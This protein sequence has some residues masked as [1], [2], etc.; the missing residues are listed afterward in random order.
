MQSITHVAQKNV[1]STAVTVK[2]CHSTVNNIHF[3]SEATGSGI[4]RR[5]R[6]ACC[7]LAC[8]PAGWSLRRQQGGLQDQDVK[9]VDAVKPLSLS[10][11]S[12]FVVLR[13]SPHRWRCYVSFWWCRALLCWQLL[14]HRCFWDQPSGP[15]SQLTYV[16]EWSAF[17]D[18]HSK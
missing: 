14:S 1:R 13:W 18:E 12:E 16:T 9:T 8:L 10:E 6:S 7:T 3:A 5:E 17:N 15:S 2:L 4:K 11:V